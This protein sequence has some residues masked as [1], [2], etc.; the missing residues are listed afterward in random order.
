MSKKLWNPLLLPFSS[1]FLVFA[2]SSTLF[3]SFCV[4]L[5]ENKKQTTKARRMRKG[6][7]NF[8]HRKDERTET[9]SQFLAIMNTSPGCI[10]LEL[11]QQFVQRWDI[12]MH[13]LQIASK[14]SGKTVT[15]EG[16]QIKVFARFQLPD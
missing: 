4:A 12:F 6:K 16:H 3:C 11:A 13:F 14:R 5:P 9:S 8:L 15:F 2:V 1:I 10:P 7:I